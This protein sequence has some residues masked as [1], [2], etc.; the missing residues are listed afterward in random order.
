MI[1]GVTCSGCSLSLNAVGI[2]PPCAGE[3]GTAT[4]V[5]T[6]GAPPYS[7]LWSPGGQTSATIS[8]LTAGTY[9]VEVTDSSNCSA[10]AAVTIVIP[11]QLIADAGIDT[12][13]CPG[14]T[15][16]IGGDPTASGGTTP[17]HYSWAELSSLD[18]SNPEIITS[19]ST[20]YHVTVTDTNGCV[21]MD[22]LSVT[23]EL[24]LGIDEKDIVN[25]FD[26]FPNPNNGSFSVKLSE[27]VLN[28]GSELIL[29]DLFGR[30]VMRTKIISNAQIIN[31][32]DPSTGF[33]QV[34]IKSAHKVFIKKILCL[35]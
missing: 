5:V 26:I 2:N 32:P 11:S 8:D 22:S 28:S 3:A 25:S 18:D 30:E 17:Y 21:T 10:S 14:V 13:L 29:L 35:N 7:Y 31:I 27:T 12:T 1:S 6:N 15:Y 33:Y 23:I 20:T 9:T 16:A 19:V 34:E 24:C 4:A